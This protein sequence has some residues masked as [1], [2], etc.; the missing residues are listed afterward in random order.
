MTSVTGCAPVATHAF[1]LEPTIE[2]LVA[3][4][5]PNAPSLFAVQT[6]PPVHCESAVHGVVN[7]MPLLQ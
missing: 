4:R 7:V 1:G 2:M 5:R 6:C 3:S